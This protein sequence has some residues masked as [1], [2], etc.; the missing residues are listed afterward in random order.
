MQQN[1][2]HLNSKCHK[3]MTPNCE[4]RLHEGKQLTLYESEEIDQRKRS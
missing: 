3:Q 4:K 2:E 1:N